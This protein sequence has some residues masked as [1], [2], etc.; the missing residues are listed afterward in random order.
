MDCTRASIEVGVPEARIAAI[1]VGCADVP[2]AE[3]EDG[4]L[5]A[6]PIAGVDEVSGPVPLV[7]RVV[8][9][10]ANAVG[11]SVESVAVVADPVG[12]SEVRAGRV[13]DAA[14]PMPNLARKS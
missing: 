6:I 5:V 11:P 8:P 1:P 3:T 4:V 14:A 12:A 7:E 10:A 9:I 2:T 13:A